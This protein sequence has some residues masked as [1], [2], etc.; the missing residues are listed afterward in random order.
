MSFVTI[1]NTSIKLS[2]IKSFGV[3]STYDR[4]MDIQIYELIEPKKDSKWFSKA[5][6]YLFNETL[7][8]TGEYIRMNNKEYY[9]ILNYERR[10]PYY[11]RDENKELKLRKTG[12][13]DGVMPVIDDKNKKGKSKYLYITTFQND[14]YQF[15]DDQIEVNKE[16]KKLLDLMK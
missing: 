9:N 6:H 12:E 13:R 3:S 5:L 10:V 11:I 14:N 7:K 16:H 15:F 8:P 1:N 4:F 2:N